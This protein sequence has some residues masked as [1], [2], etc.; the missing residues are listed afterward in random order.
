MQE[1]RIWITTGDKIA[2]VVPSSISIMREAISQERLRGS[3]PVISA[4]GKHE[5]DTPI[6]RV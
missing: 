6:R 2:L 4:Q 3:K 1:R 5:N